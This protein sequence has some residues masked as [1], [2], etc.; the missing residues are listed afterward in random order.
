MRV[1]IFLFFAFCLVG[2][3]RYTPARDDGDVGRASLVG[4][5]G[6][7]VADE[8]AFY[9][10]EREQRRRL[11]DLVARRNSGDNANSKNTYHLGPGDLV[12]VSVFDV[13]ELNLSVRIRPTGDVFLPLIGMVQANGLTENDFE[14]EISNRLTKYV[15]SPQVSAYVTEYAAHK[16]S[17]I[18]Q[19]AQP[20]TYPLTRDSASILEMISKAGGNTSA[21]SGVIILIPGSKVESGAAVR[22]ESGAYIGR[23]LSYGIEIYYE[24]LLGGNGSPALNVSLLPGDTI[25]VQSAGTVNVDGE[26]VKPG[27]FQPSARMT[28]LGSIATAGGLTYSADV[29][30]VEVLRD[31]G[32]G[33]KAYITVDLEQIALQSGKDIRLRDGDVVRVPSSPGRFATRQLVE[34]VN[35]FVDFTVG[36]SVRVAP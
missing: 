35:R 1:W 34:I 36:G 18:G 24:D 3:L 14:R 30:N 27:A 6:P 20:G 26:V 17:V 22:T 9:R 10:H 33:T 23:D 21:A 12:Q 31:I 4:F 25:V 19:V 32:G 5:A 8:N 29:H 16:V 13:E 28:L 7:T 11:D 15:Y 2:C